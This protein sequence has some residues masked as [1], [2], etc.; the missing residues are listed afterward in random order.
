MSAIRI[1]LY[2]DTATKPTNEMREF[3]CSCEVGDEQRYEDP[4]ANELQGMVAE[5]LGK[6]MAIFLPSGTMCNHIAYLVHCKPGDMVLMEKTA[7]PLISEAG[8][9]CALAGVTIYPVDGQKGQFSAEQVAELMSYPFSLR[10]PGVRVVSVE[11]TANSP[12]GCIWP[13]EQMRAV[14]EVTHEKGAIAHMDGA[15]LL[16]AVVATGISPQDYAE[17]F[18]SV[19]IDL[20]KGL[21]APV[22][23]VLAGSEAFIQQAWGWKHR[24]GGAMRQSGILAAAGIYALKHNVDRLAEDH[25]NAK[26]FAKGI[27]SAEGI[28]VD[29][30]SVETNMVRFDVADTGLS[31]SAFVERLIGEEGVRVSTPGPTALRAVPHLGITEDDIYSAVESIHGLVERIVEGV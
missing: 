10:R 31:S 29:P 11:Q 9:A 18:D 22:G 13:L 27:Y 7:H 12:G 24:L 3:M 25:I 16:N 23:G 14:C 28:A 2:S 8:G 30:D 1:D 20:S 26:R 6:E 4:S 5:M 19:W 15:R 21:G 17:T